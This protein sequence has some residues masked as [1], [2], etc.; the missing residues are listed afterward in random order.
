[1]VLGAEIPSEELLMKIQYSD[2][3]MYP[4]ATLPLNKYG[5]YKNI[6]CK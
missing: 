3:Y 2:C 5:Y 4:T 6:I 1:M